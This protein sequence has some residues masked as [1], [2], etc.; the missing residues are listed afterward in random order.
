[1]RQASPRNLESRITINPSSSSGSS[2]WQAWTRFWFSLGDP[3]TLGFMRICTGLMVLYVHLNY[4]GTLHAFFGEDAWINLKTANE[5]RHDQPWWE[6]PLEGWTQSDEEGD[7]DKKG[8]LRQDEL[9]YMQR[10][11]GNP[12][13]TLAKGTPI[14]SIWFHVVN[15]QWM[16]AVHI[17]ILITMGLFTIGFCTRITAILT[18]LAALS[19]IQRSWATLFGMDTMMNILLIYLMIGPS[20]A[21]F[22]VDSWLKRRRLA[23]EGHGL[24]PGVHPVPAPSVLANFATRLLQ[25]HFCII[26]LASATSKLQGSSWWSGTAIWGVAANWEFNPMD[27]SLYLNLVT[28]L[29][30]HRLL[31]EIAMTS[32]VLFTLF[33]ELGFPFLVWNTRLRPYMIMGSV[34]LHI[35]IGTIMGLATF[36]LMMLIMVMGFMPGS[37]TRWAVYGAWDWLRGLT[38]GQIEAE[39]AVASAGVLS[40]RKH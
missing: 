19:Y 30:K 37:V 5:Y 18:W 17:G 20:G 8:E 24:P 21:A 13:Y 2:P 23:K 10:W 36:S 39:P 34:M 6:T 7:N 40:L 14:T 35:G 33:V 12:R 11:A 15:P 38:P 28:F 3:S 27:V 26:Y 29:A 16:T 31:W 9:D 22:S 25:I 4:T 32:G 1:M